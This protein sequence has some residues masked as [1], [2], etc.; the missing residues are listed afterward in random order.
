MKLK[1][2]KVESNQYI[3]IYLYDYD[4]V[5]EQDLDRYD[6]IFTTN[7]DSSKYVV[8]QLIMDT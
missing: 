6:K 3:Y 7:G 2:L 4:D 5:Y 8:L 1:I